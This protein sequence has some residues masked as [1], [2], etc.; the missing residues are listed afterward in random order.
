MSTSDNDPRPLPPERPAADD[1]CKG[2]C[3]RCVF[4]VYDS[5][6][7]R[8]RSALR[9]WEERQQRQARVAR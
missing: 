3:E 2:S 9:A 4:D 6:L 5:A 1:C 8:Y 7:E